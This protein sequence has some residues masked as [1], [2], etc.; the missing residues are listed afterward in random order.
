VSVEG[1]FLSR[2][3]YDEDLPIHDAFTLGYRIEL[4]PCPGDPSVPG[5]WLFFSV[6]GN[7]QVSGIAWTRV[8]RGQAVL[9]TRA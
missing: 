7:N 5:I 4:D 6:F 3:E 2:R 8:A 1:R 9:E